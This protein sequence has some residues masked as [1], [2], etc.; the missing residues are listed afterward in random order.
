M[1]EKRQK[2]PGLLERAADA[3]D[4]PADVIA[5]VP[6]LELVGDREL[7]ME[8]HKGILAYGTQE[9]HVSGGIFGVKI[10]GDDLELRV[11]NGLELLITG[12]ISSIQII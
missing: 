2:R 6:R 9:I 12:Q 10:C 7:R 5:G 4:L 11:M 3:F 8:N 1:A